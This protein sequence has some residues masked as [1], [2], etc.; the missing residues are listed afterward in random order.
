MDNYTQ[1]EELKCWWCGALANNPDY[2]L[3][4]AGRGIPIC[5]SCSVMGRAFVGMLGK[6]RNIA[7]E[8]GIFIGIP[9]NRQ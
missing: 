7:A 2:Y 4:F 8:N 5:P 3:M 1:P 6:I 9:K